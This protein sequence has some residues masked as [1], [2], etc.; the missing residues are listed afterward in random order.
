MRPS[1]PMLDAMSSITLGEANL[2]P[3]YFSGMTTIV[4]VR[5][6]N[7]A[8]LAQREGGQAALARRIGKDKNQVNQWLGRKGTRNLSDDTA[9]QIEDALLLGR[10]WMDQSHSA[11]DPLPRPAPVEDD[12]DRIARLE[13]EVKGFTGLFSILLTRLGHLQPAEGALVAFELRRYLATPEYEGEA[14]PE[15]LEV[16]ER[17][18][19]SS[20]P[21]VRPSS[22]KSVK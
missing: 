12:A 16:V 6:A 11:A 18:V 4:E 21:S 8:A 13:R 5:R 10:G 2:A 20:L 14:L 17:S 7:L 1:S 19:P 22:A 9:R 15:L 3:C